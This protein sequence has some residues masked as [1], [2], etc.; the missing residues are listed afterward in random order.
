MLCDSYVTVK[1]YSLPVVNSFRFRATQET[2]T[3]ADILVNDS[4]N[5]S[6][7]SRRV[8]LERLSVEQWQWGP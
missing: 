3:R 4:S 8:L 7:A 5:S 6:K 1:L 2:F